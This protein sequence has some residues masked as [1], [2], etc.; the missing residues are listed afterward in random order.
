MSERLERL[1]AQIAAARRE[2][3]YGEL[4][5]LL[6]RAVRLARID[7]GEDHPAHATSLNELGS[8]H[9]A[10]GDYAGA[11]RCFS[12]ALRILAASA[13]TE[14]EGYATCLNN[15]AG[16]YRLTGEAAKAERLFLEA[17]GIYARTV[18]TSHVLYASNLNN[19]ALLYHELGDLGR[20]AALQERALDI[21]RQ[22]SGERSTA[23]ATSLANL[24]AVRLTEGQIE[25]AEALLRRALATLDACDVQ[26]SDALHVSTTNALARVR[27]E[28]G[29]PGEALAMYRGV[30][31]ACERLWGAEH[32]SCASTLSSLALVHNRLG[33]H[34]EA[35]RC[36][37]R[38]QAIRRRRQKA[39]GGTGR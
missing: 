21:V 5:P 38:A 34:A 32:P 23:F 2:H 35:E 4:A 18:G 24:A 37:Q 1:Q 31:D 3:R 13:G 29:H 22:A 36:A 14:H 9:R 26:P 39:G 25:T 20:A 28:R 16:V 10:T 11:E 6:R 8:L 17:D 15:L 12:D 27:F 19:L 33:Q 7:Y 30:L